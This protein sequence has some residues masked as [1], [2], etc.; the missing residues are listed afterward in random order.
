MHML[1][2]HIHIITA[3][4]TQTFKNC[5]INRYFELTF[6]AVLIIFDMFLALTVNVLKELLNSNPCR[7][8]L[9]FLLLVQ[10]LL[11]AL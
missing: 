10:L 3:A 6:C 11:L 7:C 8:H 9:L 2:L 5:L 1:K 4:G